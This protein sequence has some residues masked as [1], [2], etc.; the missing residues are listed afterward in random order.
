MNHDRILAGN[1]LRDWDPAETKILYWSG[2]CK[3]LITGTDLPGCKRTP[4]SRTT[5]HERQDS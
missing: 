5:T 1:A 3:A 2:A 4:A